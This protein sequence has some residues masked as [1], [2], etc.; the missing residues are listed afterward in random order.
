MLGDR[1]HLQNIRWPQKGEVFFSQTNGFCSSQHL[2]VSPG[3][4]ESRH[5]QRGAKHPKRA[6]DA[7]LGSSLNTK[8]WAGCSTGFIKFTK[9]P[10]FRVKT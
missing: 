7:A 3:L 9:K 6:E 5:S 10:L 1:L 8:P 2:G 4:R